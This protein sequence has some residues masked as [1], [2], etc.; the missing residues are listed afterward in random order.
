MDVVLHFF[1]Y[2]FMSRQVNVTILALIPKKE[3]TSI[4]KDCRSISCCTTIYKCNAKLLANCMKQVL[5]HFVSSN[6]AAFFHGH[7]ISDNIL[8]AYELVHNY[9]RATTSSRSVIKIDLF[10]AFD[11]LNWDFIVLLMH[12]T[13]FPTSYIKWIRACITLPWYSVSINGSLAGFF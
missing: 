9:H 4:M 6:W 5:P 10:K 3:N 11:C 13:G 8:L 1:H 12:A 2:G 7:S